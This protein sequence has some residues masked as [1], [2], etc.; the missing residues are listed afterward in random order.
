VPRIEVDDF[1]PF[2][3]VTRHADVIEIERQAER[4]PN[5]VIS[6]SAAIPRS[7]SPC[8]WTWPATSSA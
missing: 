7:D 4:F 5:T 8:S 1:D 2:W 3:A 6:A